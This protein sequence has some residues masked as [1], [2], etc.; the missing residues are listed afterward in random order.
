MFRAL[1]NVFNLC[2]A[3]P[4]QAPCTQQRKETYPD[5]PHEAPAGFSYT[6][7]RR[8]R[9]Q[10]FPVRHRR[11][12]RPP[13]APPATG[14]REAPAGSTNPPRHHRAHL[15][16]LHATTGRRPL[17]VQFLPPSSG[18]TPLGAVAFLSGLLAFWKHRSSELCHGRREKFA[19]KLL[20][21][22]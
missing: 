6:P 7:P 11:A 5:V 4:S 13:E 8:R 2:Q 12:Q 16:T 10:A 20:K 14:P 18:S 21:Q 17:D 22:L 19:K 1:T 15:N 3:R 9:D